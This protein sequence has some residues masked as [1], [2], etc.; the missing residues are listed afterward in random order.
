M[1]ILS[2]K[3]RRLMELTKI[4]G[5]EYYL[6][7]MEQKKSYSKKYY[8][9]HPEQRKETMKAY[10][11]ANKGSRGKCN[12]ERR[13]A[14]MEQTRDCSRKYYLSHTKLVKERAL[15]WQ[16]TNR[17]R[18]RESQKRYNQTPKGK[19][20]CR[21]HEGNRRQ[22]GFIP[23]NSYFEGAHAHH[24]DKKQVIY[25]PA[26]LHR[27]IPHSVSQNTNME[28]INARALEFLKTNALRLFY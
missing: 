25:V 2:E 9:A 16:S 22:L 18:V 3:A 24:I 12:K 14:H 27:N 10:Y 19:I 7:H 13:Q 11:Q 4:R 26:E 6:A 15:I 5:R 28:A 8:M 1:I 23:L 20:A 21:K 17:K